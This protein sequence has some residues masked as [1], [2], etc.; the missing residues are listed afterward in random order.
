M[1]KSWPLVPTYEWNRKELDQLTAQG[2]LWN[3]PSDVIDLFEK[4][5]ATFAGS[6]YAVA[7]DCCSHGI[8]L[9]LK[10]L[11][12]TGDIDVPSRTYISVPAQVIHAGC[13]VN[14][15]QEEWTGVYQLTP[16][17]IFDGAVRWQKD[18]YK[19][20]FHI[21]SFQIK[22]RIPIGKG[23]MILTDDIDAYNWLKRAS[24]DGRTFGVNF[25]QDTVE[26]IGWHYNMTPE[27]AARGIMLMDQTA[28]F[29]EDSG[30]YKSYTDLSLLSIFTKTTEK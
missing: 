3:S 20:G 30:N 23:G 17:P 11:N 19:G 29:N 8:F 16:Y 18:M 10:Y 25:D 1:Y 7:I 24:H 27:D 15:T 28:D 21:L 14:F 9:A 6:K 4:K 22:K 5:V 12:A 26:M 13:S 2:Y